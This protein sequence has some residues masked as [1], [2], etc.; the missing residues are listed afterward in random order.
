MPGPSP[1]E[2]P[3]ASHRPTVSRLLWRF[4][5]AAPLHIPF[6][7]ARLTLP[8]TKARPCPTALLSLFS[9]RFLHTARSPL[10]TGVSCHLTRPSFSPGLVSLSCLPGGRRRPFVSIVRVPIEIR[11]GTCGT[12]AA[13]RCLYDHVMSCTATDMIM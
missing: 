11:S 3:P 7:D 13:L 10:L 4:L 6:P 9:W 1:H 2:S 12:R 8:L 5:H